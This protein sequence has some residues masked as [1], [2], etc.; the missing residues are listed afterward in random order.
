MSNQDPKDPNKGR[1]RS[2]DWYGKADK[3]GFGH[4][5]W[6]KNRGL[7]ADQFDG[8]PIIGICNTWSEFN[9]CNAHF[10]DIAERVK[11]GVYEAG[12][13]PICLLYTSPSPRDK[14]QSRMPS[15]A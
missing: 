1:R 15:S 7:P 5:S 11:R 3:D 2:S 10:R 6:M 13:V 8:R 9:P 4:R 14:R 12:G